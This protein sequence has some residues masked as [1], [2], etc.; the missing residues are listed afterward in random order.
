MIIGTL[1]LSGCI[2]CYYTVITHRAKGRRLRLKI[3]MFAVK[4][5][6]GGVVMVNG[7]H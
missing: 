7:R 6:K 1:K 5:T 3:N 4:L 2:L